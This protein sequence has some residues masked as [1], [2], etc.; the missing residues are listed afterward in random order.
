VSENLTIVSEG[1]FR[2]IAFSPKGDKLIA[3]ECIL[4]EGIC[5]NEVIWIFELN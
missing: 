2:D 4:D 1:R 5:I 3:I